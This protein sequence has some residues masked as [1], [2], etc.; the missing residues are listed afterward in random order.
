LIYAS[1]LAGGFIEKRGYEM[2]NALIII[3]IMLLSAVFACSESE[4]PVDTNGLSVLEREAIV[5]ENCLIL[6]AALDEYLVHNDGLCP[7]DIYVDT[8]SMGHTVIDLLPD[9]QPLVNPFTE[10][11]T[12]PGN[13]DAAEPGQIGYS[14][15]YYYES[16]YN[17]SGYG[18]NAVILGLS[19]QEELEQKVIANCMHIR[20]AAEMF[21]SLN[22]GEFPRYGSDTTP[23]GQTLIDLLPDGTLL[24]N[25]FTRVNTEPVDCCAATPGQSGYL[26]VIDGG[27]NVGY[28]ITG[29]GRDAGTEIFI[30][31]QTH[32]DTLVVVNGETV[33]DTY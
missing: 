24:R 27:L 14:R 12:E 23:Q 13:S 26:P 3:T 22:D 21:A 31:F 9:G 7:D 11:R 15:S 33:I 8:N 19:N 6:Q 28:S 16:L 2:R 10:L 29:V 32:A 25:P 4:S 20:I 1:I 30:W 5:S 18:A 17:I